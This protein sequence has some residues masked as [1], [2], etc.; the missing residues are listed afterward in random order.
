MQI[1]V[2]CAGTPSQ[3][4]MDA[5][6]QKLSSEIQRRLRFNSVITPFAEGQMEMEHG[7][8]GKAKLIR[9]MYGEDAK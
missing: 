5:L 2:E 8:T 6:A 9:K 3:E 1:W 4:V 7:A